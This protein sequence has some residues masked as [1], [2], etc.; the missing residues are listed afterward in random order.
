MVVRILNSEG[1][2]QFRE[3]LSQVRAGEKQLFPEALLSDP[4]TSEALPGNIEVGQAKFSSKLEAARYFSEKFAGVRDVDHNV[5]LWS[6][7]ALFYFD[8]LCP[9]ETFGQR[10]VRE[11]A[12]YIP[13]NGCVNITGTCSPR[14]SGCTE[15]MATTPNCFCSIQFT[16]WATFGNNWHRDR[17]SSRIWEF[18]VAQRCFTWIGTRSA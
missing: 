7:L 18:W 3:Y 2:K 10:E 6:W 11:D 16:G 4:V 12:R 8:Q 1:I 15:V 17:R 5:G 9:P 14:L 13:G